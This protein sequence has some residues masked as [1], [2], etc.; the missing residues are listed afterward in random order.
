MIPGSY[1]LSKSEPVRSVP[2]EVS[3]VL[4]APLANPRR[5]RV[6]H[7]PAPSPKPEPPEDRDCPDAALPSE[8]E[9]HAAAA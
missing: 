6:D 2:Q 5:T 7:W 8:E 9:E 3:D 4:S 1:G